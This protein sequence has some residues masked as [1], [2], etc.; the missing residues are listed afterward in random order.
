MKTTNDISKKRCYSTPQIEQILLD[1]EISLALESTT[2]PEGP[3]ES[4][5]GYAP[6]YMKNDPFKN[7]MA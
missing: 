5:T 3:G 6:E 2:P 4:G 7:N 1:N